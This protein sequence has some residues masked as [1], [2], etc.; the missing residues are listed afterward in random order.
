MRNENDSDDRT[1][2]PQGQPPPQAPVAPAAPLQGALPD[3]G[4]GKAN[5][6]EN[7]TKE[8]AREFRVAEKWVIGTNIVLAVIGIAALCIYYGQLRVM[9]GQLGEIIKQYPEI[10][11]S[12]DAAK[13]A[14]DT[15]GL[16]VSS[17]LLPLQKCIKTKDFNYV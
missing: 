14:A 4:K 12:A 15:A 13:S 9:R 8:L 5:E 16:C 7:E 11:K 1:A 3:S 17:I 10:K 2:N 6:E